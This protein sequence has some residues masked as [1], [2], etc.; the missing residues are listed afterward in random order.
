[1]FCYFS[2]R[3]LFRSR[4]E[5]KIV[6]FGCILL[7][8]TLLSFYRFF[9]SFLTWITS[10]KGVLLSLNF[11]FSFCRVSMFSLS[12]AF[13]DVRLSI[14]CLQLSCSSVTFVLVFV[15]AKFVLEILPLCPK[16]VLI[17]FLLVPCVY[18]F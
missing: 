12:L 7:F 3:L 13:S 6:F 10:D 15:N 14:T 2:I 1:M 5:R 4:L 9:I 8:R 11:S 16:I 17:F 18:F